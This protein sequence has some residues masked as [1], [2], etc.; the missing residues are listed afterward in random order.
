MTQAFRQLGFT[1]VGVT[2]ILT[3]GRPSARDL[4]PS[5][6]GGDPRVVVA[7]PDLEA[8]LDVIARAQCHPSLRPTTSWETPLGGWAD[9]NGG[10]R[11][12]VAADGTV[13]AAWRW[14]TGR[15]GSWLQLLTNGAADA[16]IAVRNALADPTGPS[17]GRLPVC[18]AVPAAHTLVG[19]L[20][21]AGFEA[22]MTV[23]KLVKHTTARILEP[24]WEMGAL[25]DAKKLDG[26]APTASS[27]R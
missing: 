19:A 10:T 9:A 2:R 3:S 26:A 8:E 25:R 20:E 21:A 1:P 18:T 7:G 4:E 11:V 5:S 24:S 23:R 22:E 13:V 17:D 27:E 12:A 14:F 15:R 6:G 16:R